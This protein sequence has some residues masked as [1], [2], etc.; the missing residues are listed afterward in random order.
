MNHL[1]FDLIGTG[2]EAG[3][4]IRLAQDKDQW[5]DFENTVIKLRVL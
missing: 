5:R 3:D 2:W 1:R 4:W